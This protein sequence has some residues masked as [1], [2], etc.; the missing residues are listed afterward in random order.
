MSLR[1]CDQF[2]FKIWRNLCQ[3]WQR[4]VTFDVWINRNQHVRTDSAIDN[5]LSVFCHYGRKT[6]CSALLGLRYHYVVEVWRWHFLCLCSCL[7]GVCIACGVHKFALCPQEQIDGPERTIKWKKFQYETDQPQESGNADKHITE[8]TLI[9]SFSYFM[10]FLK[11]T[12]QRFVYHNF[13]AYW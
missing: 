4:S 8:V 10:E 13:C 11:P 9:M 7:T 1:Y 2:F 12:L 6:S 5:F 3:N